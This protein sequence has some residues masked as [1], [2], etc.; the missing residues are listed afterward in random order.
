MKLYHV[1]DET[2]QLHI[3]MEKS[4]LFLLLIIFQELDRM[5]VQFDFHINVLMN[6]D[7]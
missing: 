4:F 1:F 2:I 5:I 7:S 3:K 6:Q